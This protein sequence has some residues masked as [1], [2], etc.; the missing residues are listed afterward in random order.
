MLI[1]FIC[2][3]LSEQIVQ[4]L[5]QSRWY[6]LG[7]VVAVVILCFIYILLLRWVVAPVVWSSIACLFG[8]LGFCKYQQK[9]SNST[10]KSTPDYTLWTL[11]RPYF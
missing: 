3:Q 2:A 5:V 9:S 4:D 1:Y 11:Y 10:V 7:A 8:A 6:M